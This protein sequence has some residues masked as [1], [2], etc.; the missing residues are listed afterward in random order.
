MVEIKNFNK[1]IV[2]NWK[3]NGSTSFVQD[4]IKGLDYNPDLDKWPIVQRRNIGLRN[5]GAL[6]KKL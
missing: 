4:Y 3:L 2:A 5:T 6:G 1:I